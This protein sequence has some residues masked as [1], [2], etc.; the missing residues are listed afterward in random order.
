MTGAHAGVI[1]GL[2][3]AWLHPVSASAQGLP[4]AARLDRLAAEYREHRERHRHGQWLMRILPVRLKPSELPQAH[5]VGA[6][7][8]ARYCTQC[9]ELPDPAMH[10]ASRWEGIVQRMLPRMRGE[11]N[12]GR[13]MQDMMQGLEAP[14]AGQ[15]RI[16][17]DY[18]ASHA[19]LPL[20]FAERDARQ[21]DRRAAPTVPQ[22]PGLTQALTTE[23]GRMFQGAC[24]Q[25]HDLPDPAGHRAA[26]WPAVVERMQANMQWMNRVVGSGSNPREPRLDPVRITGFLQ[27]FSSDVEDRNHPR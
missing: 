16:I 27:A 19:G 23:D 1:L 3:M 20:A 18:L 21:R 7:T 15:T 11:G 5:S 17:T 14:D 9:H 24:S 26:E 4:D 12:Q 25:C 13:L 6:R 22:R 10:G 8:T 2:A